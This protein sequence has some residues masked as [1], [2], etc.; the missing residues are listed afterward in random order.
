MRV[1]IYLIHKYHTMRV[2]PLN[3]TKA[4]A[5]TL[6][7]SLNCTATSGYDAAAAD[8]NAEG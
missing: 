8:N 4:H 7:F 1:I 6:S 5:S 2:I 3:I